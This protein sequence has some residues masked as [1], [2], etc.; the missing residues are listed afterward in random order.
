M[1]PG[2]VPGELHYSL[3][4]LYGSDFEGGH[5]ARQG[6]SSAGALVNVPLY[7]HEV[8][9]DYTRVELELQYTLPRSWDLLLRVP[10]ERKDQSASVALVDP[11]TPEQ[12]AAMLRNMNIHHRSE[13]YDGLGDLMLLG[14]RRWN[15]LRRDGDALA[16]SFGLT[17]PTGRTE[18]NP[19]ALGAEGI[20]HLHIQFGSGT[21]DPLLEAMYLTR[22]TGGIS[23]GAYVAARY[24][25]Y[26]NNR[27]FQAPPEVS[28]GASLSYGLTNRVT[29]RA[30]AGTYYQGYGRWDG[31]RD[32]NTGLVATS[33]GAGA[34]YRTNAGT[35][36]ADLRIPLSQRT[37]SEGDAFEQG[38]T[39]I[40]T[41]SGPL[42]HKNR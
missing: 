17:V 38:P 4:Y 21:V 2:S 41:F 1:E 27:T 20:P 39:V 19:Y 13:S 12:H 11:A 18:E 42:R 31:L 24:P 40:F 34:S 16:L 3:R 26:E 10:W 37:L 25:L 35:L 22:L 23:T 5:F 9:L 32:E 8:S 14:R 30:E 29:V 7:R 33:A 6:N 15:G 36:N 28:G